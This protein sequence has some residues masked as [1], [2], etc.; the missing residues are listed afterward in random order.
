MQDIF[1]GPHGAPLVPEMFGV[2]P[3][4]VAMASEPASYAGIAIPGAYLALLVLIGGAAPL[5]LRSKIVAVIILLGFL[6]SFSLVGLMGLALS[7][8]VIAVSSSKRTRIFTILGAGLSIVGL[9]IAASQLTIWTKV[10]NLAEAS[11]NAND[12]NYTSTDLSGFALI[13]N[14]LVAQEALSHSHY[15]GTGLNT[16][17]Y[18]YDDY[19]PG[20]FSAPKILMEL[21]RT[22]AG[23]LIIRVL[24]E[25]GVPGI[26]IVIWFVARYKLTGEHKQSYLRIVNDLS[27][28]FLVTRISRSGNYLDISLWLFVALYYYTFTLQCWSREIGGFTGSDVVPTI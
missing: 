26:I 7:I 8:M 19:I 16:H 5:K 12:Y 24:S 13:S 27:F 28:V 21:N 14:A 10:V 17:Q 11:Q 25:L 18:N 1:G 3:R 9:Y 22:D 20:L 4:A 15:L 2:L 23:S 6:A